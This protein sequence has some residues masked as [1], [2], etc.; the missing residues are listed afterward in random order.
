MGI[1]CYTLQL[2]VYYTLCIEILIGD[3]QLW[4]E[5]KVSIDKST[6]EGLT[7]GN[8]SIRK[9]SHDYF[10]PQNQRETMY[11]YRLIINFQKSPP[12]HPYFLHLLVD[13]PQDGNDLGV[14]QKNFYRP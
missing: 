10:T 3:Y 6:S 5:A 1:Q 2:N 9:F 14:Y 13:I 4:H 8:V 7:I 12:S 11:Y